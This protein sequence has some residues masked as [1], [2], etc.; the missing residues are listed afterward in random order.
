MT[1]QEGTNVF[2]EPRRQRLAVKKNPNYYL[3]KQIYK[4][5]CSA[6]F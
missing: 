3:L 5:I 6:F 2:L 1:G 4:H